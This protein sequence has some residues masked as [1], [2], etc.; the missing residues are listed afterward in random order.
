M[1]E[2]IFFNSNLNNLTKNLIF[3]LYAKNTLTSILIYI[4]TRY[5][6]FSDVKIIIVYYTTLDLVSCTFNVVEICY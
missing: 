1:D 6:R 4:Q 2:I 5:T 3:L